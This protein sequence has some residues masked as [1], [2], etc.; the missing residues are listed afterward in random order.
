M[1]R[2]LHRYEGP[3]RDLKLVDG[4]KI[5]R[6]GVEVLFPLLLEVCAGNYIIN[7]F[8]RDQAETSISNLG[9]KRP[10]FRHSVLYC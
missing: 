9:F 4:C 6:L 2:L 5:R 1:I 7:A 3:P 10:L 8:P